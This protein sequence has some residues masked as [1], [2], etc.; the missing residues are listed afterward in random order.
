MKVYR[1]AK[2]WKVFL[3]CVSLLL[4]AISAWCV[5]RSE[6]TLTFFIGLG[7]FIVAV[8]TGVKIFTD[9]LVLGEDFMETGGLIGRKRISFE[10]VTSIV[11]HD[12]HAFVRSGSKQIHI[13]REIEGFSKVIGRVLV[14]VRSNDNVAVTGDTFAVSAHLAEST[15]HQ[16]P[17]VSGEHKRASAALVRVELVEKRWLYRSIKLITTGGAH[18]VTYY[19]RGEGYECVLLDGQVVSKMQSMLWYAPKFQFRLG[20]MDV[21]VNVRVWP[22]LTIRKF[23]VEVDGRSVYAEGPLGGEI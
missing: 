17:Q 14:G 23:W 22:W 13:G 15:S 6:D 4:T 16:A 18:N 10:D 5:F 12:N 1:V 21:T 20:S 8:L 2:G 7:M 9:K 11:V 3:L 19:G